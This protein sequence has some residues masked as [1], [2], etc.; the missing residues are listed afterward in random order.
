MEK[1]RIEEAIEKITIWFMSPGMVENALEDLKIQP[2]EILVEKLKEL[3]MKRFSLTKIGGRD[4][5][6][7]LK[8]KKEIRIV[9]ESL[10]N[11]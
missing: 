11:N 6:K 7:S 5:A 1:E 10:K 8:I 3:G 4:S 9:L 2:T